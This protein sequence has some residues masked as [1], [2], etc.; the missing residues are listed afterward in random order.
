MFYNR[1]RPWGH[2][3]PPP[4]IFSLSSVQ[5]YTAST[6]FSKFS[7]RCGYSARITSSCSHVTSLGLYQVHWTFIS[8]IARFWSYFIFLSN[9]CTGC[10]CRTPSGSTWIT[11]QSMTWLAS[12][13]YFL[14]S[15]T[16]NTL[17]T[18]IDA[19]NE[20][21]YATGPILSRISN[22]PQNHASNLAQLPNFRELMLAFTFKNTWSP[23]LNYVGVLPLST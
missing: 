19:G 23:T 10:T 21:M 13:I 18:V 9:M 4:L 17:C 6:S 20:S 15:E 2:Y 22:G 14:S 3:N 8:F 12:G 11:F 5:L 16:W 7:K 1:A